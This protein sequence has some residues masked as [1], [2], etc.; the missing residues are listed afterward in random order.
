MNIQKIYKGEDIKK[1]LN[2]RDPILMVN[3]LEELSEN[4]CSA[5]LTIASSNFFCVD[6]KFTEPGL[7]EHIAQS[8][9][10]FVSYRAINY[11]G[12]QNPPVGYIGEVKKFAL[13][14]ELP[15]AGATIETKISIQSEVMNVT[16]F[17][18]ESCVEGKVVATCQMKLSV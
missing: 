16:M 10:A 7:I 18:A 12:A 3:S 5:E 13:L 15:I 8:A 1:L 17:S 4:E 6:G 2:Q 14:G 9:S 11:H